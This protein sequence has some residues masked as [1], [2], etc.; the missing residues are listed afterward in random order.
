M[1]SNE[2]TPALAFSGALPGTATVVAKVN[3]KAAQ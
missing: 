3:G 1:L 2:P